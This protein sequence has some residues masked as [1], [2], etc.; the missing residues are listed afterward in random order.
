MLLERVH[1]LLLLLI[2]SKTAFNIEFIDLQLLRIVLVVLDRDVAHR[3]ANWLLSQLLLWLLI[4]ICDLTATMVASMDAI[5]ST[6]SSR[7][8]LAVCLEA[9]AYQ[10][11]RTFRRVIQAD[12]GGVRVDFAFG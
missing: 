10:L 2:Q 4:A 11:L 9:L 1:A 8:D 12:F 5:G 7:G 3:L 6:A